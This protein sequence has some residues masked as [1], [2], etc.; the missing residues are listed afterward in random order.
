MKKFDE[1]ERIKAKL[2]VWESQ[3][4]YLKH[5][6]KEQ[7]TL[8]KQGKHYKLQSEWHRMM[9]SNALKIETL[10]RV[11]FPKEFIGIDEE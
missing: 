7:K 1:N 9:Y 3:Q 2:G 4:K 8:S 11:M 10:R 6:E 5:L